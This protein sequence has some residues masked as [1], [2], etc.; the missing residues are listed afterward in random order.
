MR[1]LNT[2]AAQL[3]AG[4]QSQSAAPPVSFAAAAAA[5]DNFHCPASG[6]PEIVRGLLYRG[7]QLGEL[8]QKIGGIDRSES[9]A[10]SYRMLDPQGE[11][12]LA[13]TTRGALTLNPTPDELPNWTTAQRQGHIERIARCVENGGVIIGAF[14]RELMVGMTVLDGEW[15][16]DGGQTLDMY[17]L[18]ASRQYRG[19]SVGKNL[20]SKIMAEAQAR[21]AERPL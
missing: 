13:V 19:R 7:M 17:F 8:A 4:G 18:F 11:P 6:E 5:T 16:G 3:H 15:M 1:R 20:I 9:R 2:V 10:G 14:E 12:S 21:L